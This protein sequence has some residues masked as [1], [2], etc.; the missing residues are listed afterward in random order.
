[1]PVLFESAIYALTMGSLI[2]FVMIDFLHIDPKLAR[3]TVDQWC[4]V[5]LAGY[6][7]RRKSTV[8]QAEVHQKI[9]KHA[10]STNSPSPGHSAHLRSPR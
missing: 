9:I 3:T 7:T 8:R 1:M 2:C 6:R 10:E 5:S 4:D